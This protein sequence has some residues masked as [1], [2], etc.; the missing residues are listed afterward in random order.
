MV[1]R[2][3]FLRTSLGVTVGA[4]AAFELAGCTDGGPSQNAP[5]GV[6]DDPDALARIAVAT[7]EL[8]LIAAYDQALSA[9]PSLQGELRQF[10]DAHQSHWQT[11]G[12]PT[13]SA[14]PTSTLSAGS[15]QTVQRRLL[16]LE[17]RAAARLQN[18]AEQTRAP[19]LTETIV[20]I[21]AAESQ[22]AHVLSQTPGQ[23]EAAHG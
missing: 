8:A 19:S 18:L 7:A 17:E 2:R 3:A 6:P 10:R 15:A 12:V 11:M 21:S 22:H 13:P 1:S 16:R 4:I 23:L 9:F 20:L 5:A 14:S